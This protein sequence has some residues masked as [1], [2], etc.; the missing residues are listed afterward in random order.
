MLS[1]IVLFLGWHCALPGQQ[2]CLM[3]RLQTDHVGDL[4]YTF[5]STPQQGYIKIWRDKKTGHLFAMNSTGKQIDITK[6]L[7]VKP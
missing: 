5:P 1:T 4:T 7:E 2:V 3:Q 6:S